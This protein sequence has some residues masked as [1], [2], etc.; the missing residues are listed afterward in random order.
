[1][2]EKLF[3]ISFRQSLNIYTNKKGFPPSGHDFLWPSLVHQASFLWLGGCTTSLQMGYLDVG[4]L[5]FTLLKCWTLTCF[6]FK[7][8]SLAGTNC[9]LL[10]YALKFHPTGQKIQMKK[11]ALFNTNLPKANTF[12]RRSLLLSIN[13]KQTPKGRWKLM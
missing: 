8:I 2:L 7:H 9:I 6:T 13:L 4:C 10:N 12:K 11:G 5:L 3:Q 1:M